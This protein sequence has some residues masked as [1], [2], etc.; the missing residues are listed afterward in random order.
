MSDRN[1]KTLKGWHVLAITLS[2]F[3]VILTANMALV[4][5]ATGSFPGTVVEDSYVA[6][7]GW[8]ERANAQDALGWRVGVSH[9]AEGLLAVTVE[10]EAGRP[11]RGLAVEAV[12]GRPARAGTDRAVTLDAAGRIHAVP[13]ALEP[14]LWRV[15]LSIEGGAA[16]YKAV[17]EIVVPKDR[18]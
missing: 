2:A 14:G 7:V 17:A 15:A 4:I 8:N 10:D 3:G 9:T 12:V 6:G 16:P 5:A 1:E 13:L 18:S 11:V